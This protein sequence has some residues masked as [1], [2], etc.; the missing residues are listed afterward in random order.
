MTDDVVN[1][2]IHIIRSTTKKLKEIDEQSAKD[3]PDP[4]KWSIQE[5]IGHLL[6]SACNNH[7][8]F[9]RAQETNSLVFPGYDQDEWIKVQAYND[10]SWLDLIE[11]WR[12]FNL[13]L[14]QVIRYIPE[15]KLAVK[16]HSG[17][18][19]DATL[20]QVVEGYNRHIKH[21]LEQIEKKTGINL[22][23]CNK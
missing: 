19:K 15:T 12:L 14:A 2:L 9:V 6:D 23:N 20:Q 4:A 10:S 18:F 1:E 11:L 21:H 22:V 3:K 16:C 7:Q 8:R 17:P 13:H 5:I